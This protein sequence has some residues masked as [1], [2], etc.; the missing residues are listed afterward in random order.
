MG[1]RGPSELMRQQES[2]L[3]EKDLTHGSL[4]HQ[5]RDITGGGARAAVF[6][7]SDG[8]VSNV[9]LVLGV[10]GAHPVGNIV[11][12]AGLAGLFGGAFSM[13]AGEYVSMRAQRELM[14]RELNLER[15]ELAHR[16]EGEH[17][18]LVM[19]YQQRGLNRELAEQVAT[20]LMN[21]PDR[22][23]ETHAREELG[24]SPQSLGSPVQ[25]ALASFLTFAIGACIPLLPFLFGYSGTPTILWAIGVTAVS[26]LAVG[27]ILSYFTGKIWYWSGIRQ[28]LICSAAGAV[29]FA[30]G[31]LM[32]GRGF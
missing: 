10:A 3:A 2:K 4:E 25:A 22:A 27:S 17:R 14:E 13:A 29:T 30:I 6:G 28:L 19:L 26:A 16:P 31:T 21:S 20:N 5:H 8:L 15:I 12:L 1:V 18:E 24:F 9:S 32:S 23:L 7:V 11:L